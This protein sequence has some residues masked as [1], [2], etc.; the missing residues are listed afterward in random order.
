VARRFVFSAACDAGAFAGKDFMDAI[1][2]FI[3]GAKI[4]ARADDEVGDV[5]NPATGKCARK[6][7]MGGPAQV[8]AAVKTAVA[9]FPAWAATPPIN[10]ARVLLEF[11][12]LVDK[13]AAELA[14][15]ITSEH[16]KVLSD[17]RGE[18][19]RGIEVVEFACGI[20]QL[21]K[22]EFT[23]QVGR[24]IDSWSM[25]QP[26]GVCAG[27]TPF[28][29]P[30]MVP[31]WMFPVAIAC[32][33]T[34]ILKPSERDPSAGVRLA[35]L[36]KEAG[37]PDGVFNVVHGDKRAVDAILAHRGIAA[38]SFVGSTPIAQYIYATA[39]A[40]GKRVQA[41]GGAKNH[42]L[43]MPDADLDQAADALVGAAYGSAGE[44]CMAISV[45]VAVGAAGDGLIEQLVPR[46]EKLK[47][48]AGMDPGVEMGPLVTR[49][50]LERVRGYVD[51]GIKEGAKLVIDGRRHTVRGHEEGFFIGGC[52][53]DQ[54][55]PA[56]KI[57]REEI[58][59]PVLSVVRAPD[60]EAGLR[61]ISEHEFGNGTSIFTRDGCAAR[62]FASRVQIGMVGVN[63]PI[64]VPM[65]FHSFGGWKRSMFGDMAMHG[66]EGVRFYTK[67]KT[68]TARWPEH[69]HSRAEFD[70]PT[71]R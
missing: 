28:N 17:A 52:L 14:E 69:H 9:A 22:G 6:V 20:P 54:V 34:F 41:L 42:M 57:Y 36:L 66:P 30:A 16:G 43:V 11:R 62:E 15:I 53:F 40:Q 13:H 64:P 59:G 38:V 67:L 4:A 8:D 10:R 47:I 35:E 56:M 7:C 46:I 44:R 1:N 63:V 61:L 5:F 18:V 26:L 49:Q 29:F 51:L 33:N 60:F 19:T 65:A 39:A 58:F 31:M 32:G 71:T 48:G 2:H 12:N 25:R 37:L 24:G 68:V 55:T 21:L 27:I 45:A 50:H 3:A 23:E 70:M